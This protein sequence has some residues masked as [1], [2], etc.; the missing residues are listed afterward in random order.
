VLRIR[1]SALLAAFA[2]TASLVGVTVSS[3]VA[4]AATTPGLLGGMDVADTVLPR[5]RG[6]SRPRSGHISPDPSLD[7][8]PHMATGPVWPV[9]ARQRPSLW[10]VSTEFLQS[11]RRPVSGCSELRRSYGRQ[12]CLCWNCYLLP[13]RRVREYAPKP[14]LHNRGSAK[15]SRT[16]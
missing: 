6:H 7:Q 3:G 8:M 11:V 1:H 15:R 4:S 9:V 14:K 16:D 5:L 10:R 2:L 13:P 12:R